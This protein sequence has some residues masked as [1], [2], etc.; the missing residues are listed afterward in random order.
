[1]ASSCE[2]R[3]ARWWGTRDEELAYRLPVTTGFGVGYRIL[4][5]LDVRGEAKWNRFVVPRGAWP[6]PRTHSRSDPTRLTTSRPS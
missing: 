4:P 5:W 1:M 6:T 3:E 2:W